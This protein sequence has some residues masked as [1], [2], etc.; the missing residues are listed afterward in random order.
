LPVRKNVFSTYFHKKTIGN[1]G[2]KGFGKGDF[3]KNYKELKPN[4]IGLG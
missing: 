3:G 4:K 1:V 2:P